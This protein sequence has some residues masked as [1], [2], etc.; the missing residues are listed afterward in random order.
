ML[1]CAVIVNIYIRIKCCLGFGLSR[2]KLL[3]GKLGISLD[4]VNDRLGIC[5]CGAYCGDIG[6]GINC[7]LSVC[8]CRGKSRLLFGTIVVGAYIGIK[9]RFCISLCRYQ[10]LGG[11]LGVCLNAVDDYLSICKRS[12]YCGNIGGSLNR[13]LSVCNCRG[14]SS[15]LF[16]A[17]VG[18]IYI[19]IKFCLCSIFCRKQFFCRE[20]RISLDFIDCRFC[21]G[22]S[23]AYCGNIGSTFN[24][25]LSV[26]NCSS[27]FRFLRI[28]V[29]FCVCVSF[30]NSL[31]GVF[32]RY[33]FFGGQN[34]IGFDSIDQSLCTIQS[35]GNV[36]TRGSCINCRFSVCNRCFK[37]CFFGISVIFGIY[38]RFKCRF[39]CRFCFF[40][41]V[42][43]CLLCV[44][45]RI[46]C[47]VA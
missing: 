21:G 42:S 26:G 35:R 12:I 24:C 2:R 46:I 4:L 13:C 7:A 23:V 29:V 38:I 47:C 20:F 36:S 6:C 3:G 44:V 18:R 25:A 27:Q 9:S 16:G 33:K 30:K 10:F 14:E 17:I 32:R 31:S 28:T 1:F 8:N 41:L 40:K 22:K 15:L 43:L 11:K 37:K 19:N 5:K 39:R 45:R 34:S